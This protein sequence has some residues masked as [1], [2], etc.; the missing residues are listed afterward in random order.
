MEDKFTVTVPSRYFASPI[1]NSLAVSRPFSSFFGPAVSGTQ[2]F[3]NNLMQFMLG[4]PIVDYNSISVTLGGNP[5]A[6]AKL[7]VVET[8]VTRADAAT[9]PSVSTASAYSTF[10]DR[11]QQNRSAGDR[12]LAVGTYRIYLTASSFFIQ[13]DNL[14]GDNINLRDEANTG[15]LDAP[16]DACTDFYDDQGNFVFSVAI[17]DPVGFSGVPGTG[18][19]NDF[20][21]VTIRQPE[22][23][24]AY[25]WAEVT[26]SNRSDGI[27]NNTSHSVLFYDGGRGATVDPTA[28]LSDYDMQGIAF[29]TW[30]TELLVLPTAT[31]S[32]NQTVCSGAFWRAD[33]Y[34]PTGNSIFA[35]MDCGRSSTSGGGTANFNPN[36]FTMIRGNG[37]VRILAQ[38]ADMPSGT[39]NATYAERDDCVFFG[40][41]KPYETMEDYPHPMAF[42]GKVGGSASRVGND[43]VRPFWRASRGT[44]T[45]PVDDV[46]ALSGRVAGMR[47][48]GSSLRVCL[49]SYL[50]SSEWKRPPQERITNRSIRSCSCP[51]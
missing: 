39:V 51:Q 26:R 8:S 38:V 23:T 10:S 28:P 37:Y 43:S 11:L 15:R 30:I 29:I 46:W 14:E 9:R 35:S 47:A 48:N 7:E 44:L 49:L 41:F 50:A 5:S 42:L 40:M 20:I 6:T 33:T 12:S 18:P 17:R 27:Q 2:A 24:P 16:Y 36:K 1:A 34:G 31:I 21:D 19:Y 45:E 3:A 13:G 25:N 22:Y 32:N 4:A